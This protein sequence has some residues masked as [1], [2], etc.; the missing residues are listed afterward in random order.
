MSRAVV[1]AL[2]VFLGACGDASPMRPSLIPPAGS[3]PPA[4]MAGRWAGTM[5]YSLY[6]QPGSIATRMTLRADGSGAWHTSGD[7]GGFLTHQGGRWT[8]SWQGGGCLGRGT[9]TGGMDERGLRLESLD[10]FVME[11]CAGRVESVT[12]TLDPLMQALE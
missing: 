6:N 4:S 3:L 5:V 2:C 1:V 7:L 10:G 9:F 8:I 12:W 11:N